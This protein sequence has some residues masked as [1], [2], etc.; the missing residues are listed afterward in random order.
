[1]SLST[2]EMEEVPPQ[3][4]E[5]GPQEMITVCLTIS[6]KLGPHSSIS[7]E[8]STNILKEFGSSFF[9]LVMPTDHDA[10]RQY[11]DFS[12]IRFSRRIL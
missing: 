3:G 8:D 2:A 6:K 11:L 4:P 5:S 12:F 7:G 9:Y 1:M 10:A